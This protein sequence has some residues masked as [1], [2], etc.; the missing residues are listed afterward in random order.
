MLRF[1]EV[2]YIDASTVESSERDLKALADAMR[3][4]DISHYLESRGTE[5]LLFCDNT[6][7]TSVPIRK[8]FPDCV[9]GNILITT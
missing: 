6:D 3:V 1:S 7:D 4:G 9:Y 8:H 2:L 5:W